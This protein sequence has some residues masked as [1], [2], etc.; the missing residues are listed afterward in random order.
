MKNN[1]PRRRP[2]S[3]RARKK[4]AKGAAVKADPGAKGSSTP[5][6]V[7]NHPKSKRALEELNP[8]L[9]TIRRRKGAK[10]IHYGPKE[11]PSALRSKRRAVAQPPQHSVASTISL[12][13]AVATLLARFA[14]TL[15][16][17]LPSPAALAGDYELSL[18]QTLGLPIEGITRLTRGALREKFEASFFPPGTT[19]RSG[20][21]GILPDG[22]KFAIISKARIHAGGNAN[23]RNNNPGNIVA[24]AFALRLGAIGDDGT[25]AIFPTA[26]AGLKALLALLRKPAYQRRTISR[27][28]RNL[29]G[30]AQN[31]N[32]QAFIA[33]VGDQLGADPATAK[34]GEVT[35]EQLNL[36]VDAINQFE[37]GKRGI[38][39]RADSLTLPPFVAEI[40]RAMYHWPLSPPVTHTTRHTTQT[41]TTR[42]DDDE[43]DDTG[44]DDDDED[45]DESET[46][47]DTEGDTQTV[48]TETVQTQTLGN[49]D[50]D[51]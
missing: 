29:T 38:V 19:W 40:F 13:E 24:S 18:A 25:F 1:S 23:W 4:I 2:Q 48:Q 30:S 21:A 51:E 27:A 20:D 43:D 10:Y 42:H 15:G 35:A 22:T 12:M 34:V 28:L 37:G 26:R 31:E 11:T 49:E 39:Y 16:K 8:R 33:F 5:E 44:D 41:L 3:L 14:S 9:K 6:A 32:V 7:P 50:D 46:D 36:M 47:T 45:D 17:S